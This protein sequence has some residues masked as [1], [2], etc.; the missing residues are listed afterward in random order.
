MAMLINEIYFVTS[1]FN[2]T[3]LCNTVI[4]FKLYHVRKYT[5]LYK[6]L[7]PGIIGSQIH[8]TKQK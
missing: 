2:N 8:Q 1:L 7:I 5:L 4:F 6:H 3:G